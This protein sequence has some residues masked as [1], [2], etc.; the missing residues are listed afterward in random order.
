[1]L[2]ALCTE[3]FFASPAALVPS[4]G[5]GVQDAAWVQGMLGC[6]LEEITASTLK[7]SRQGAEK[8]TQAWALQWDNYCPQKEILAV[9]RVRA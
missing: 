1:M 2:S 4:T 8:Q 7:P 3:L 5:Q 6:A 9:V